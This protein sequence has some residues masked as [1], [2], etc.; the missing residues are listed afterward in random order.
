MWEVP[1][2]RHN[3]YLIWLKHKRILIFVQ[4]SSV[5]LSH[6]YMGFPCF[7]WIPVTSTDATPD[8]LSVIYY[9]SITTE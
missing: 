2:V 6:P 1:R 8:K 4:N 3:D 5:I 9:H 7:P